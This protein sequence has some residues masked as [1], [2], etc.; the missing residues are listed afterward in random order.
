MMIKLLQTCIELKISTL[1]QHP[2]SAWKGEL[3]WGVGWRHDSRVIRLCVWL[4]LCG[5]IL[6]YVCLLT[7]VYQHSYLYV[8]ALIRSRVLL[9][10][11]AGTALCTSVH[12][13]FCVLLLALYMYS[14]AAL[15]PLCTRTCIFVYLSLHFYVPCGLLCTYSCTSVYL[16]LDSNVLSA[17]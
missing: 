10:A 9:C 2:Q 6:L 15:V 1:K 3:G 7:S 11:H 13:Y 4:Y 14:V 12:L 17:V 16:Y 8:L 5:R